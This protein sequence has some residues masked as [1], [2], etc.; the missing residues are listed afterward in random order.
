M[1]NAG[2]LVAFDS[3]ACASK[4]PSMQHVVAVTPLD[5]ANQVA[6]VRDGER[7]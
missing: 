6:P 1:S 2:S 4:Q 7:K 3:V 5:E